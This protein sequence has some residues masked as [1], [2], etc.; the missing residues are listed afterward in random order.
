VEVD[1]QAKDFLFSSFLYH[2]FAS[3][4]LNV[5]PNLIFDFLIKLDVHLRDI[6]FFGSQ[7]DVFAIDEHL[8]HIFDCQV[9]DAF[10]HFNSDPFSFWS[11]GSANSEILLL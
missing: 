11:V 10:V 7:R 9:L 8:G 2:E 5:F 3:L 1:E 6:G 4:D